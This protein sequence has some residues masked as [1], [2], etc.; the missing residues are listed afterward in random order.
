MSLIWIGWIVIPWLVFAV[1]EA[2]ALRNDV[3][4]DTLSEHVRRWLSVKTRKGRTLFLILWLIGM[5]VWIWFGFHI[6]TGLV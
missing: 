1:A 3:P 2:I 5:G 4:G 6:G